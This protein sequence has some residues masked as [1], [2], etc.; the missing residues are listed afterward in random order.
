ME[1][2]SFKKTG[3]VVPFS[4]HSGLGIRCLLSDIECSDSRNI[5]SFHNQKQPSTGC[6]L[7]FPVRNMGRAIRVQGKTSRRWFRGVSAYLYDTWAAERW[8][9]SRRRALQQAQSIVFAVRNRKHKQPAAAPAEE[10]RTA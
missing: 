4:V 2:L 3:Q 1:Q 10:R 9:P 5:R 6:L 7:I 8:D